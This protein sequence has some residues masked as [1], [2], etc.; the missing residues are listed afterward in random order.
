MGYYEFD[1][2]DPHVIIEKH[3]GSFGSFMLGLAI[4]ATAALL[5][6]PRSGVEARRELTRRARR[7]RRRAEN[8]AE[9]VTET[10]LDTFQQAK[11]EVEHRI[12]TARQAVALKKRQVSRAMEAGK[13]AAQDARDELERRIAETKA[14]YESPRMSRR[15]PTAAGTDLPDLADDEPE[16]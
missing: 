6:A 2:D 15:S 12:D 13:A 5:L 9:D 1:D 8:L 11:Q 16:R 3:E 4:G 10:V 14:S 7:A